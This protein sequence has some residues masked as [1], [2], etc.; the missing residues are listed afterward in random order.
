[1]LIL[2]LTFNDFFKYIDIKGGIMENKLEFWVNKLHLYYIKE[3]FNILAETEKIDDFLLDNIVINNKKYT[4]SFSNNKLII[5]CSDKR[6][7]ELTMHFNYYNDKDLL[8]NLNVSVTNSLIDYQIGNSKLS[9]ISDI[10]SSTVGYYSFVDI[11]YEKMVYN[12]TYN[13][14]EYKKICFLN[15]DLENNFVYTNTSKDLHL[16]IVNDGFVNSYFDNEFLI[17]KDGNNLLEVENYTVDEIMDFN[18]DSVILKINNILIDNKTNLNEE[19]INY[20]NEYS[21]IK[22]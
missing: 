19:I 18:C 5:N 4:I 10:L 11:P 8:S 2:M 12:I 21:I 1:M 16:K 13:I 6:K 3:I 9:F 22:K 17:S 14:D 15:N 20:I 7:L